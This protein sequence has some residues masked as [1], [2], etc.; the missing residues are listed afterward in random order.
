[1]IDNTNAQAICYKQGTQQEGRQ[2]LLLIQL[3]AA[4]SQEACAWLFGLDS[5][6]LLLTASRQHGTSVHHSNFECMS[7]HAV[8]LRKVSA[9]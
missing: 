7:L 5:Q 1:M 9:I 6:Y 8:S 2:K 4:V 3:F